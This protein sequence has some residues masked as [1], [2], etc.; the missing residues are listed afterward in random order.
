LVHR[1]FRVSGSVCYATIGTPRSSFLLH[2]GSDIQRLN[3]HFRVNVDNIKGIL[4]EVTTMP[5]SLYVV[6]LPRAILDPQRGDVY[7]RKVEEMLK[8]IDMPFQI[9]RPASELP[10]DVADQDTGI[11]CGWRQGVL[12]LPPAEPTDSPS[13]FVIRRYTFWTPMPSGTDWP[14]LMQNPLRFLHGC[15]V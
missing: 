1:R 12:F 10:G 6:R 9:V 7:D 3:L 8:N 14:C 13:K 15:R 5:P 2:P 11:G 4:E